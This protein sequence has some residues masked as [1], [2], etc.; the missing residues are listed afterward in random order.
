MKRIVSFL[1]VL[2]VI[3]GSF[4]FVNAEESAVGS[5][6][7]QILKGLGIYDTAEIAPTITRSDFV[8]IVARLMGI[9][10]DEIP[11]PTKQV[12][13]D[14]ALDHPRAGIINYLFERGI[15]IG[16]DD[17]SFK[18]DEN[19][20]C[21]EAAKILVSV[22]G[23]KELAEANGGYFTGYLT[24]ASDSG[25]LKGVKVKYSDAIDTG[26]LAIMMVNTMEADMMSVKISG[27]GTTIS[28]DEGVTIMNKY[29]NVGKY[30]GIVTGYG[31]T[32]IESVDKEYGENRAEI[33]GVNFFAGKTDITDFI[34][35]NVEVYY[36]DDNGEYTIA[37]IGE[38]RNTYAVID[39]NDI[40]KA[41]LEQIEYYKDAES[42]R[43]STF[44][45]AENAAFIYNGK[46]MAA[47]TASDL[48]PDLGSV[49]LIDNNSDGKADVVIINDYE[50]FVVKGVLA[51]E[52]KVT[53]EYGKETLDFSDV[54]ADI[55]YYSAGE[56]TDFSS[57]TK[58]SVLNITRSKNTNGRKLIKVYITEEAVSGKVTSIEHDEDE[59]IVTLDDGNQYEISAELAKYIENNKTYNE[60]TQSYEYVLDYPS[61][62]NSY[63]FKLNMDGKIADY[64]IIIEGKQ[65]GYI[66]KC[67]LDEEDEKTYIRMFT[68]QG[69][70]IRTTLRDK[71][72][73]NGKKTESKGISAVL[74]PYQLIIY[75]LDSE[76]VV[77]K[78]RT[79]E[80]KTAEKWYTVSGDEFVLHYATQPR[81]NDDGSISYPGLRFYKNFAENQPFLFTDNKT[82]Y[83][84]I[85]SDKTLESEYKIVTKLGSTDISVRGPL[86]IYDVAEG[87]SIGAMVAGELGGSEDYNT[88]QMV[89]NVAKGLNEDDEECLKINFVDGSS[90]LVSNEVKYD[91]PPE[92]DSKGNNNWT[93]RVDYSD[94]TAEDLKRGDVIQC[95][96]VNG[97]AENIMVLVCVDNIGPV[98]IDGDHIA[99]SGN[100]VG[101]VL[102]VNKEAS[103]AI[104]YYVD[105]FGA[106]RWQTVGIGGSVFKYDSSTGKAD[107]ST[108]SDI[109][110]GDTILHNSFWWSVKATFIFR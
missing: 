62:G 6:E 39:A 30:T 66:V 49:K 1:I 60:A 46:K 13:I 26:N 53:T 25:I 55:Q 5:T 27:E 9:S 93:K 67:Y 91:Q 8:V 12:F 48:L 52:E 51:T 59:H 64:S 97:Y 21:Q 81:V 15:M 106:E 61:N 38:K 110:P 50:E 18:P 85:P 73:L 83:F 75:E 57:I 17:A 22:L 71:V 43:T 2:S 65:Y 102:S 98:R 87:G 34:G 40:E 89:D 63:D 86:Y 58:N 103:R 41:E 101:K 82:I 105:R 28:T 11:A 32:S 100:I 47:I 4:T 76:G 56:L 78:I 20:T 24:A 90:V 35:M 54:S 14:V 74:D 88:P 19:L 68:A 84:Q 72:T 7:A 16:H 96:V 80:D 104:I 3:F 95:K 42:S 23:Y 77:T 10:D 107:Y 31:Y 79:A 109:Q 94:V 29:L 70:F 37:Y 69:E 92:S 33:G 108:T 44:K 45:I 36:R 99:K